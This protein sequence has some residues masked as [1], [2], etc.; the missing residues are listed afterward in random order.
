MSNT[1][2]NP[3]GLVHTCRSSQPDI[4]S[5]LMPGEKVA[6][7]RILRAHWDG[8]SAELA[9]WAA[10]NDY[11]WKRTEEGHDGQHS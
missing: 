9:E 6:P 10:G 1:T 3:G 2:F 5:Q 11:S 4:Y 7:L 8:D